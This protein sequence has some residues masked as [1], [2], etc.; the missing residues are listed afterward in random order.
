MDL[1]WYS[2]LIKPPFNPP[3]WVFGPAWTILYILMAISAYLVWKKGFKK[4]NV[5]DA[6]KIFGIQLV[7][8][9]LWSPVFF[10]LKNILM[11]LILIMILWYFILHTIREFYKIDKM[12][13]YLLYPYFAWVSFATILNL[14]IWLLNR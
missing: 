11:A 2:T 10:G 5:K 12:A 14:S 7:L 6:L 3:S 4:K 13:A 8:N 9:L 1:S